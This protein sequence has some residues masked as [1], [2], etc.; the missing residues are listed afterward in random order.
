[1]GTLAFG[2]EVSSVGG[3]VDAEGVVSG[4]VCGVGV[5]LSVASVVG[6]C[7]SCL[8]S[9]YTGTRLVTRPRVTQP[10]PFSGT[11]SEIDG[12]SEMDAGGLGGVILIDG[13]G[14]GVVNF[15]SNHGRRATRISKVELTGD[16]NRALESDRS[17]GILS[18]G[19]TFDS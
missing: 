6:C 5:L 2:W 4:E 9:A 18:R 17:A 15:S 12:G 3:V 13:L 8:R 11:T 10:F 16:R 19:G 1:M 14:D 7:D